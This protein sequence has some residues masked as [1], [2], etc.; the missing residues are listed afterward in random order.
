MP[1]RVV[2]DTS[3]FIAALRSR[4]GASFRLLSLVGGKLF[5]VCV[6]VP[7]MLEYEGAAKKVADELDL[8]QRDI[9]DVLDYLARVSE[10]RRVYFLWR[11]Y[12]RDPRDDMLLELAVE[13]EC[14][15]IVTHNLRHFAGSER[16]GVRVATPREFL[17]VIGE[18]R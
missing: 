12:L 13:A 6:S 11:P 17:R 4:R 14:E 3:V 18:I 2:I 7:L 15:F 16:F 10:H 9:D 1:V 8:F 5:S